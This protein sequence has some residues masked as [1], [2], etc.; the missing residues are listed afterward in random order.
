MWMTLRINYT[1]NSIQWL[2]KKTLINNS[3]IMLQYLK[4]QATDLYIFY[5]KGGWNIH[6]DVISPVSN[7]S[8]EVSQLEGK[9]GS[10]S[11]KKQ[12][13]CPVHLRNNEASQRCT[14][15]DTHL[16]T[17]TQIQIYTNIIFFLNNLIGCNIQTFKYCRLHFSP[18][19]QIV[20]CVC[21]CFSCQA[22]IPDS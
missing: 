4:K 14:D 16:Y 21:F 8:T 9:A 2:A 15:T 22:L 6:H 5:G 1:S 3:S 19:F 18:M 11:K 7:S 12:E 10:R 17:H 20:C 13:K